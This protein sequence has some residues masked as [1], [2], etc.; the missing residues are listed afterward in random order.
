[1]PS[2]W[3]PVEPRCIGTSDTSRDPLP[4]RGLTMHR[5]LPVAGPER[6]VKERRA[7]HRHAV[8]G[9]PR[10]AATCQ[11]RSAALPHRSAP[12]APL[13]PRSRRAI[14][15]AAGAPGRPSGTRSSMDS[16]RHHSRSA[17]LKPAAS[18][19]GSSSRRAGGTRYRPAA[20]ASMSAAHRVTPSTRASDF[21]M[22]TA[23]GP[24]APVTR[25]RTGREVH[26]RLRHQR[27]PLAP[28]PSARVAP[29]GSTPAQGDG[30][31]GRPRTAPP[32]CRHRSVPSSAP[33]LAADPRPG[34]P[35]WWP[36]TRRSAI[37]SSF[38]SMADSMLTNL[39]GRN[40]M[41]A[42]GLW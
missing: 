25:T 41:V 8:L 27:P 28:G 19:R 22:D 37:A 34:S 23:D 12:A 5:Q 2:R 36:G 21:M 16:A 4:V 32:R 31:R 6:C 13:L 10:T 29:R 11:G 17:S 9:T 3:H 18:P 7:G 35:A 40:S 39:L 1:M 42:D 24:P 20:L 26:D 15:P 38:P 33:W 14:V 30:D